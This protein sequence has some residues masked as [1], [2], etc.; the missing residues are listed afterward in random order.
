MKVLAILQNMW[1]RDPER[2]RRLIAESEHGEKFRRRLI[3]TALF[4]GCLTGRR[5][6]AE[7]GALRERII[8]EESSREI[9]GDPSAV[10]KPDPDH[11]LKVVVQE[12][13]GIVITFGKVA[14]EGY[15]SVRD[16]LKGAVPLWVISPHPAARSPDSQAAFKRQMGYIRT[17]LAP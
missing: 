12:K 15:R 13:P 10:P 11:I 14:E 1:V 4:G 3:A 16:W 7:L 8:W 17:R 5:L 6:T 9:L 2:V